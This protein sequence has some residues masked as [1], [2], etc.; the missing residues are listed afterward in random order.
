MIWQESVKRLNCPLQV[1]AEGE[2]ETALFRFA[3][4]RGHPAGARVQDGEFR[5]A[6]DTSEATRWQWVVDS[7]VLL[8]G[9]WLDPGV[10]PQ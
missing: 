2:S 9:G 6:A 10:P 1:R 4:E 3:T 5:H 7:G 8:E